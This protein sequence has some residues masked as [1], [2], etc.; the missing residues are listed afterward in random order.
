MEARRR[1]H[2]GLLAATV[3]VAAVA[4]LAPASSDAATTIGQLN[5]DPGGGSIC[6]AGQVYTTRAGVVSYAVPSGGGV[7]T[8]WSTSANGN[9]GQQGA[10][11]TLRQTGTPPGAFTYA[12]VASSNL[13]NLTP[14]TVNRFSTRISVQGGELIGYQFPT[15]ADNSQACGFNVAD[16][17][18]DFR[19]GPGTGQP[20]SSFTSNDDQSSTHRASNLTATIEADADHDGFGD[21]T[22]DRCRGVA[23]S[24]A[25]CTGTGSGGGNGSDKTKPTVSGLSFSSTTFKAASSG[26]AFTS[27]VPT[28][29]KVSFSLSEAASVKFTVQRK[30]SG[31]KVGRKCKAPTH[32]N[33]KKH[34]CTRWKSVRGSF[35]VSGKKGKN[36][37]TFRG[38][39]GGK[40]LSRGSYRL[41]AK[42]TDPAKNASLPKRKG[43]RIVR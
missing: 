13:E 19:G 41:S 27:K 34:K 8:S 9:A 16:P 1:H 20:G 4:L 33:R 40:A 3:S 26:R 29:T 15:G 30:A 35:T 6:D 43:F 39:I 25:G 11:K 7:I 14:N 12:V 32:S 38:R 31:R 5:P 28:G 36:T 21:E 22:Q 2:R 23:G 37:F 18:S 24:N 17:Q 42:A 10:L